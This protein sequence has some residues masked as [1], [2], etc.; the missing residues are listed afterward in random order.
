MNQN[1]SI[2]DM[3]KRFTHIVNHLASL[4][5]T[6]PNED[7]INKVL[8]CLKGQQQPK[9]IAIA[10]SR[11]LATMT[12]ATLFRKLQEHELELNRLNQHEES[13]KRKKGIA[14]KATSST[15]EGSDEDEKDSLEGVEANDE[16]FSLRVEK[17][18]RFLRKKGKQRKI[19]FVTP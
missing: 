3:Q 12:L 5:K 17:F 16:N 9:V 8:R 2:Q 7:L 6:L 19:P 18:G 13:N 4:G 14:L 1:E 15:H 11:N 10:E